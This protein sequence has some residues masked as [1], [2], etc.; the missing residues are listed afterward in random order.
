MKVLLIYLGRKGG[1]S[2]Y[3]LEMAKALSKKCDLIAMISLQ[4]QNFEA[5][6]KTGISLIE[7]DTYES[8][9]GVILSALNLKKY[10]YLWK[11][12]KAI[13]P[14]IIYYPMLHLWTPI[15]NLITPFIPKATTIHDPVIHKGEKNIILELI[16]KIAIK[17]SA[18]IIIL[19][20]IFIPVIERYGVSKERIMVIPH[21]EFSY[22]LDKNSRNVSKEKNTILFFGRIREYKGLEVLISAFP[23]IKNA[24]PQAK[25]LIVGEGDIAPYRSKLSELQDVEVI[26]RWINDDEV[27]EIF[28][29]SNILVL[30]YIDSTQSGIIPIAYMFKIP[31][32][33]TKVG[34]IPE[35]IEDGRTGLLVNPG[36]PAGIAE[37][38]IKLLCN[39]QF[40]SLLA[41]NGYKKALKEWN[42]DLIA[43]NLKR[44][45][46]NIKTVDFIS[47]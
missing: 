11:Q 14:D 18:K 10:F 45:F 40:A 22:Y 37:A 43:E 3:S 38:C 9:L 24:V 21:G 32:V 20:K 47:S 31:V 15:I 34:G 13:K 23:I 4:S 26:N 19:S 30:P 39:P 25:L 5:W 8:I 35:Q 44:E 41:E 28:L 46:E 42:W 36:D 27:N 12:I 1:G 29:K 2:I 16:Q 33:A 7:I 6:R 17:Q